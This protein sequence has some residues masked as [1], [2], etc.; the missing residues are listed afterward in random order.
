[1]TVLQGSVQTTFASI[2]SLKTLQY[3]GIYGRV[4]ETATRQ[5]KSSGQTIR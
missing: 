3:G 4:H 5:N 1:M 2:P